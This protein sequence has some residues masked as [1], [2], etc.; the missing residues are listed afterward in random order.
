M[1]GAAVGAVAGAG[2]NLVADYLDDG[3]LIEV[4]NPI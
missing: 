3:K 2:I 1:I 4:Q